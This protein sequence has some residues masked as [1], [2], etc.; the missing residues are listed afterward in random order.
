VITALLLA[1]QTAGAPALSGVVV[2]ETGL[3]LPGVEVSV[4]RQGARPVTVVTN[5]EG[6]WTVPVASL[7]S[8]SPATARWTLRFTLTGFRSETQTVDVDLS[9]APIRTVLKLDTRF[10]VTID[11]PA[12]LTRLST[13][14][15]ST[16]LDADAL[17]SAPQLELDDQLRTTPG[18]SLFRRTSSRVANPTT[19]GVTLRGLS[20][21]GASRTL[22]L[23]D[24][25]PLNDPFGAWIYWDRV[26]AAAI[27]SVSVVRGSSSDLH[28]NDA[29]GGVV[30][31]TRRTQPAIEVRFDGGGEGTARASGYAAAERGLWR[32]GAAAETQTT[33][34]YIVVAPESR[35]PIDVPAS[36]RS[37]TAEGWVR[38]RFTDGAIVARA[39][40]FS[41]DRGNGTPAQV[42]ATIVRSYSV[43]AGGAGLGGN[44]EARADV[45]GGNYRQTFSAVDDPRKTERLTTLQWVATTTEGGALDWSWGEKSWLLG[46]GA[47]GRNIRADLDESRVVN[48]VTLA[49]ARTPAR[50]QDAGVLA[51]ALLIPV[52]RLTLGL[53]LRTDV[54]TSE[55]LDGAS[56][57]QRSTFVA[58]R[59]TVAFEIADGQ[60]L[61]ASWLNGFRAPTINEL[62][63]GFRVGNVN[64]L[65]NA[66]LRPE[67]SSGTEV[68]FTVERPRWSGRAAGF[69]TWLDGAI[70]SRTLSS[71]TRQ[72]S[73]ATAR[74]AGVELE[75]EVLITSAAALTTAWSIGDSQ[76]TG[77]DL[78]GR[79]VPQV[80]HVQGTIGIHSRQAGRLTGG[81]DW[82]FVGEQFDDDVNQFVLRRGSLLDVRGGWRATHR[83]EVFVAVENVLDEELDTGKTPIRTIGQPRVARAGL[84]LRW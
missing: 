77:G 18:F 1:L 64:T 44:W 67:K 16:R 5:A 32:A 83:A 72:R 61:R 40:Y 31:V 35:G 58:P 14:E 47:S 82:R 7:P 81:I 33:D 65:A 20:A 78:D 25:V 24:D 50:Q 73:N 11:E 63:R 60:T 27:E 15:T 66:D 4:T 45:S 28:G 13:V 39:N 56:P 37:R 12:S 68:A 6:T 30:R 3:V 52:P 10:S 21:S 76:F 43:N 9:A 48:G 38:R 74:A 70:Y 41:E 51:H 22:V 17:R 55:R 59:A 29:L 80:P 2:D 26:P 57:R 69:F 49:P 34:G 54:W 75:A 71:T 8:A 84:Q 36:S 62:Y 46:V 79:Q 53:G 19:Q 42:N 23:V